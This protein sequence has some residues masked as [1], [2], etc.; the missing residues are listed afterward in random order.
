VAKKLITAKTEEKAPTGDAVYTYWG[1]SWA[2]VGLLQTLP[3]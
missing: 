3:E 1:T 2:V